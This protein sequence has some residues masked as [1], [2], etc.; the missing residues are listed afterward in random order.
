MAKVDTNTLYRSYLAYCV[1][2]HSDSIKK[3]SE[4]D[5]FNMLEVLIDNIFLML[6]G[7]VFQ[8]IFGI[9]MGTNCSSSRR[10]CS[11]FI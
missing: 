3:F 10:L 11:L 5:I 2:H 6:G 1:K 9:P 4:A 7:R 8:Q